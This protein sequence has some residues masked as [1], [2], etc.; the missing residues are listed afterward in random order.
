MNVVKD[1]T[2]S[3]RY[4]FLAKDSSRIVFKA[5]NK[6]YI[7]SGSTTSEYDPKKSSIS[8]ASMLKKYR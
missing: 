3:E 2:W 4:T 1:D 7:L 8:E 5:G 6:D